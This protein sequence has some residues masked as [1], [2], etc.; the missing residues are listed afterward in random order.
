M[1]IQSVT[2]TIM[3]CDPNTL[4]AHIM[5]IKFQIIYYQDYQNFL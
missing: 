1:T 2:G 4:C 3:G 5:T